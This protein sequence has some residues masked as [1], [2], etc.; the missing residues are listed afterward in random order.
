MGK[1]EKTLLDLAARQNMPIPEKI[2]NAPELQ[3]GLQLY[4]DAFNALNYS[5]FNTTG[6]VGRIHYVS[7]SQWCDDHNIVGEQKLDVIHLLT[8]MDQVYSD[9]HF[10]YLKK[11]STSP[12]P[13]K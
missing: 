12:T 9:W 7:M 5:R 10:A 1:D 2:L 6:F 13:P 3:P 11:Q 8:K 4:I